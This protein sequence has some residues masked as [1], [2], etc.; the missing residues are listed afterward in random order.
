VR[1]RLEADEVTLRVVR[2]GFEQD[3]QAVEAAAFEHPAQRVLFG[4]AV[5]GELHSALAFDVDVVR[6]RAVESEIVDLAVGVT[7]GAFECATDR[8]RLAFGVA[9]DDSIVEDHPN[10][11]VFTH[12]EFDVFVV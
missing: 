9:I 6:D 12:H 11:G 10:V 8:R 2:V 5:V 1:E 3:R 4:L 7:F